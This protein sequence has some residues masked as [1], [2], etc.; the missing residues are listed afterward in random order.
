MVR[1]TKHFTLVIVTMVPNGVCLWLDS[2]LLSLKHSADIF[3]WMSYLFC[4]ST[5][6][7]NLKQ[8]TLTFLTVLRWANSWT[9][10][11][12]IRL[13]MKE[14]C[15]IRS[16]VCALI[17]ISL[18]NWSV[19]VTDVWRQSFHKWKNFKFPQVS[20]TSCYDLH[21]G[22]TNA[23]WI[24]WSCLLYQVISLFKKAHG[25]RTP[26]MPLVQLVLSDWRCTS[27]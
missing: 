15:L 23:N 17:L 1:K 14:I 16:A 9:H 13:K 27:N 24:M 12:W 18:T 11:S 10:F 4:P 5:V 6:F 26:L 8:E 22:V 2:W 25:L 19:V 3:E 21:N 7:S 20:R